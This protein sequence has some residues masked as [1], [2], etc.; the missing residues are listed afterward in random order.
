[1]IPVIDFAG[2][3]HALWG[4]SPF[5]WQTMLAERV[6]TGEWPAVLDLPT[7]SGKTACIDIALYALAAQAD[8]ATAQ[9]T[10]PRRIWFVVDRRIVVDEAYARGERIARRIREATSGPLQAVGERL[11]AVAGTDRPVA[12]ARLRGGVFRDEGWARL[13]SQPAVITSTVDQLG[14]RL[15]FRGYGHSLLAAPVYAGLAANDSLI[16]LDEAH[17][18]VPFM[19]TLRAVT[20]YR[21]PAWAEEP[22]PAPFAFAVLSATPPEG[23]PAHEIFPGT[24]RDRA[25]DHPVLHQR[26]RAAKPAR[27]V[28]VGAPRG[29]SD[30]PLIQ[31]VADR[32]AKCIAN[33]KRRVAVMVNRVR[34]AAGIAAALEVG[35]GSEVD[36]VLLTGRLRPLERD[37]LVNRWSPFLRAN[38]PQDPAK[39]IVIV[40]TQT[41]E[42]GADFSFDALVAEAASLDALRQRFGRLDRLGLVGESES[43]VVVRARDADP[44]RAEPDRVYGTAIARTWGLLTELASDGVVDFG[45][46]ALH[47]ALSASEDLSSCLAPAAD[48]PLLLPAHLDLLCQTAPAPV[49]EPDVQLYLHGKDRGSPDVQV[50][51]RADLPANP[52]TRA[53]DQVWLETVALAPPV[54]GEMLSVPLHRLRAFLAQIE[55]GD[56]EGDVEGGPGQEGESPPRSRPFV[57][58]RGR[59]RS[60]VLREPD[61]IGPNDV[62]VVPAV[63]GIGDLGQPAVGTGL[64]T[65][66]LD[67]WERALEAAG[68]P[69]A[70]RLNRGLLAPWESCPPL[71]TLLRLVDEPEPDRDAITEGIEALLGYPPVEE[72]G[73]PAPPEWWRRCLRRVRVGRMEVHPAGG[74][75]LFGRRAAEPIQGA[76]RDLFA[77]DDDLTSAAGREVTLDQHCELVERTAARLAGLCLKP[78]YLELVQLAAGWHDVGKL[79]ERFQALLRRGDLLAVL[80]AEAPLAKSGLVPASPA[81]R[82]QV[83]AAAGLPSGFRHEMLS[84][85]L[86]ERL[87]PL[88]ADDDARAL[89]LHLVASHHGHA[90]PFAPVCVDLEPP[91]VSGE[92]AGVRIALGDA[93]RAALP[94]PHRLDSGIPDRFWR[95]VR[96]HGWWGLAYLEGMVRLSDWYASELTE[97]QPTSARTEEMA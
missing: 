76:E 88:P 8:R 36:V 18:A 67:L 12:V 9:R 25:L 57:V 59:D 79:D 2:F 58:W 21:G 54:S 23:M 43:A 40:A 74:V 14:S 27:L 35:V 7:A 52:R 86:M 5:P 72:G 28:K 20:R 10:A 41:L 1:M 65:D 63:Y 91:P 56:D 75:I 94:P 13:P 24:D 44:E 33:G 42:V 55:E 50:V 71:A 49:P 95:L 31:E 83:R 89:A 51:W 64:G 11:R 46:E 78:E 60:A 45:V 48:A 68:K 66:R 82:R 85:Q 47:A 80:S 97:E 69:A 53:D 6:A 17:C 30:D 15:L 73:A 84:V 19:Q 26:F 90:R 4:Q 77:D 96:R 22:V 92:R 37:E 32:A 3:F 62:V 81:R 93:D 16:L 87:A 38:G 70:L 39:P 29:A 34:T 61:Q